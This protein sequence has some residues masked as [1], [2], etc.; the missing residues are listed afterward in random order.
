VVD[1]HHVH[2][3]QM[4][5][6]ETALDCHVVVSGENWSRIETVKAAIKERLN[7]RFGIAHSSL[8]FEHE[9][10]AHRNAGIYGHSNSQ[11]KE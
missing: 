6:H 5:E 11:G 10:H 7:E 1:V 3:W 8:E 9:D 2:L 4:Q